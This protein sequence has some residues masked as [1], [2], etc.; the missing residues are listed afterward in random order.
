MEGKP[1]ERIRIKDIA[2]QAGVSVGTV[3]R[4]LHGRPNVSE[5]SRQRVEAVLK[6]INY[7]P[8]MYASALASNKKYNF[9]CLL[10]EHGE[11]DYWV[12][13]EKGIAK[14][15]YNMKDFHVTTTLL[16]Y[17]PFDEK[18]FREQCQKVLE[19]EPSGVMLTPTTLKETR[20][21]TEALEKEEV[22]YVFIDSRIKE[23]NALTFYGQ[24][25]EKSGIF[26]ARMLMLLTGAQKEIF[27]FKMI[28]EGRVGSTQQE[29]RED[30]FRAYMAKHYPDC[31]IIELTLNA[32]NPTSHE[33]VLNDFF[34]KHK[35][36]QGITFNSKAY[37]I[38]E[39]IIEHNLKDVQIMGYDLLQRNATCMKQNSISFLI[40][41]HPWIQGFN[42]IK[43]LGEH[44]ILKKEVRKETLMPIELLT[45]ENMDFYMMTQQ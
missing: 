37:V 25:S 8:N 6:Q 30:G 23:L 2:E 1:N 29:H 38:G 7:Q 28:D 22:P 31:K 27:L 10:P 11:K 41:Q 14:A 33:A 40:T 9:I 5:A 4:V 16:H 3:D 21:F 39:Y 45:K 36:I 17:N 44:L 12:E 26:A 20:P 15:T 19:L 35:C 13:V 34:S 18:S 43:S 32:A 24:D 42:G